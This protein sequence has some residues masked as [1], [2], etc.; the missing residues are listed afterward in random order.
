[1]PQ[2]V[3]LVD[4]AQVEI[5]Y[6]LGGKT[7]ENRLWFVDRNPP[8]VQSHLD[9]L[10]VGIDSWVSSEVLP[11]LGSD[12]EYVGVDSL[13]WDDHIGDLHSPI[14]TSV[15]GGNTSGTHSANVSVRVRFRGFGGVP[16]TY[17]ANFIPG[18]PLDAVD[19]NEYTT[20]FR[21]HIF[22]AYV[23]LI[24]L[25]PTFGGFP[26]WRWVVTSRQLNNTW[27]TE[28]LARRMDIVQFPSP[29]VSP[30]RRRMPRP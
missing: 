1:M 7:V 29:F 2:F 18:I 28:Q 4:G 10:S 13:K 16:H 19:I 6:H 5:F 14:H 3:P 27:R 22:N 23:N 20:V 15:F 9:A 12:I 17:N 21:G 8:I 26:G 25:A 30:R 11:W 24:D